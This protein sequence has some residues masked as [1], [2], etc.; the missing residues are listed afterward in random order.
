MVMR[1]V[2]IKNSL[3]YLPYVDLH[4]YVVDLN[5]MFS[6]KEKFSKNYM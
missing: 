2:K 3:L 1:Y 5:H 4:D 6:I